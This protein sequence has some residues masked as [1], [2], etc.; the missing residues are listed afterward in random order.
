MRTKT[1]LILC[2][3]IANPAMAAGLELNIEIPKIDIA[4]YHRP[5]VA[6]WVER[7]DKTVAAQL[8]LWYQDKAKP[9]QMVKPGEG[10]E[11]WLPDLRQWWR[12]VGQQTTLPLDG[13]SGATRVPGRYKVEPATPTLPA[14]KYKLVVEAA[15]EDGGREVLNIPFAWPPKASETLSAKGTTELGALTL[16]LRP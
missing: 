2:G 9:G 6:A 7:E 14:G 15:R 3:L 5:Y 16:S 8:A 10:G 11:K 1:P 4:E 13:V 12:R